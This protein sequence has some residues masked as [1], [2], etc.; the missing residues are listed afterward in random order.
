MDINSCL[1]IAINNIMGQ[2]LYTS[3]FSFF[4]RGYKS[5]HSSFQN[6]AIAFVIN[7]GTRLYK[8]CTYAPY[9]LQNKVMFL[10]LQS[11]CVFSSPAFRKL[12]S[13]CIEANLLLSTYVSRSHC[14]LRIDKSPFHEEPINSS[15]MIA[16]RFN[17]IYSLWELQD[18]EGYWFLIKEDTEG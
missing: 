6:E 4:R 18:S 9:M 8:V 14:L 3:M 2:K 13:S 7:N 5:R 16:A 10:G 12:G 15:H 17:Y 11:D 1:P